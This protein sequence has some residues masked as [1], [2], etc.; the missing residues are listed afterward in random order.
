MSKTSDFILPRTVW[1]NAYEDGTMSVPCSSPERAKQEAASMRVRG[2]GLAEVLT[3]RFS[4]RNESEPQP[5]AKPRQIDE[6]RW[7]IQHENGELTIRGSGAS[8]VWPADFQIRLRDRASDDV[9]VRAKDA[10]EAQCAELAQQVSTHTRE[11]DQTAELLET[12][13]KGAIDLA[14]RIAELERQVAHEA[15][16]RNLR[17]NAYV[18]ATA[19]ATQLCEAVNR[20]CIGHDQPITHEQALDGIRE[21]QRVYEQSWE[22]AQQAPSCAAPTPIEPDKRSGDAPSDGD[23]EAAQA[24]LADPTLPQ[25]YETLRQKL[26]LA[27]RWVQL[28]IGEFTQVWNMCDRLGVSPEGIADMLNRH[29]PS[30][31]P[32]DEGWMEKVWRD[33]TDGTKAGLFAALRRHAPAARYPEVADFLDRALTAKGWHIAASLHAGRLQFNVQAAAIDSRRSFT[34]GTLA[35]ACR[36]ALAVFKG[37]ASET[38]KSSPATAQQPA[39]TG[40][41]QPITPLVIADLEERSRVGAAKY[42]TPLRSHNG[43]DALTDA[44]QEALDLT[45]YLRQAL[46]ERD[47]QPTT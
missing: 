5:A 6:L 7:A 17:H 45:Q 40:N 41:G 4:D 22:I 23:I 36:K 19:K 47:P 33:G 27:P 11:R 44:Y 14:A 16:Q 3:Y 21:L 8:Q 30:S 20:A 10:A 46:A 34:D 39:P 26:G 31:G 29:A 35:G 13:T 2:I 25:R 38:P 43:R 32:A 18:E 15:E 28:V 1:V 12:A 42:G 9:I 37:N 24:A